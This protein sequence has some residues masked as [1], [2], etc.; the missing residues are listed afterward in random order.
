MSTEGDEVKVA[1]L[2]VPCEPVCHAVSLAAVVA[3]RATAH[4]MRDKLR[5]NGHP[6]GAYATHRAGLHQV[7]VLLGGLLAASEFSNCLT[8]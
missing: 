3:L 8:R 2:W 5:M 1:F 6:A 4:P 7:P